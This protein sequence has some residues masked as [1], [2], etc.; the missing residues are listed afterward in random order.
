MFTASAPLIFLFSYSLSPSLCYFCVSLS[1]SFSSL[2]SVFISFSLY[3]LVLLRSSTALFFIYRSFSSFS[4]SRSYNLIIFLLSL[5]PSLYNSIFFFPSFL[6]SSH[7]IVIFFYI[8]L[9][10]S[11]CL[12]IFPLYFVFLSSS[13]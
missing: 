6:R 7:G 12:L 13:I 3:P 11:L 2:L 4:A 1:P 9:F 5:T 8:F 10:I